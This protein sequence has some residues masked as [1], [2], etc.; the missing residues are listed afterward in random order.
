MRDAWHHSVQA[1]L[2]P[3]SAD[4]SPFSGPVHAFFDTEE[5]TPKKYEL[6][7]EEYYNFIAQK[8]VYAFLEKR[9]WQVNYQRGLFVGMRSL[10]EE[11]LATLEAL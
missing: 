10:S 4:H 3:R 2:N 8:E 1:S 6:S 5:F 7:D 9:Q 11:I